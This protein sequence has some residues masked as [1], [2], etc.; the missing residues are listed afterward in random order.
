MARRNTIHRHEGLDDHSIGQLL[1]N[2]AR[3]DLKQ[4]CTCTFAS[5]PHAS[6]EAPVHIPIER[7]ALL[8][9]GGIKLHTIVDASRL[10]PTSL[11]AR[12]GATRSAAALWKY[13]AE[14]V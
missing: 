8:R 2:A 13:S 12:K 5:C 11:P 1:A 3:L 7:A 10:P 14:G 4:G 9:T 6:E